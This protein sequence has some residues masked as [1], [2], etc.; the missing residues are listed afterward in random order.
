MLEHQCRS[1]LVEIETVEMT[2]V[3]KVIQT[4]VIYVHQR[5]QKYSETVGTTTVMKPNVQRHTSND[6]RNESDVDCSDYMHQHTSNND[7][8]ESDV[9]CSDIM[10]QRS[11]MYSETVLHTTEI[12]VTWVLVM[13]VHQHSSNDDRNESDVDCSDIRAPRTKKTKTK[14][15]YMHQRSQMY[16]ET[17]VTTIV[18][19]VMWIVVMYVHQRSQ[20]NSETVVTTI[21]MK[22]MWIVVMYVHQRS[23][24]Y[25]ET[26]V[27]TIVMKVMWIVV[28]Y[29][30]QHSQMYI[31]TLLHTTEIAVTW[32][33]VVYMHQRSQ[34]S[35]YISSNDDRNESDVNCSDVCAPAN[36]Y[37][38]ESDVDCSDIRAPANDDRNESDV[39]CS[40]VCAPAKPAAQR[41]SSNDDR[42]G[43]DVDDEW[44]QTDRHIN[45][46]HIHA[47]WWCR[48]HQSKLVTPQTHV[49]C[50]RVHMRYHM[51]HY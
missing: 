41:D 24:M 38:N 4:V 14:K 17:V 47:K 19:K 33:L 22:V 43:C 2:T 48:L 15:I 32:V 40:D 44:G 16:S 20:M 37:R 28:I 9:N 29:V 45:G 6:D 12:A 30:H 35:L 7:R 46:Y 21:V 26:L 3:I 8:N 49:V 5:S 50:I 36:D 25:S 39:D 27:T 51:F 34:M 10:H 1:S 18:M 23:Q 31:E 42:N 13:C 11:Q